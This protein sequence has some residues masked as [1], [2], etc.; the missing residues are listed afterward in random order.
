MA[1]NARTSL[2]LLRVDMTGSL[3]RPDRLK[4]TAARYGRGEASAEEFQRVQDECIREVIAT[5][6]AHG[7]PVLTDGEFRRANFQDSFGQAVT[8]FDAGPPDW[9]P[10]PLYDGATPFRRVESG[11]GGMGPAIVNRRPARE[12]LRLVRNVPL[13]EYQFSSQQTDRPVKVAL[14]G[15]DRIAQRFEWETSSAVYPDLDAF[16]AD[17]AALERQM[18]AELVAAGCRYVQLDEPGYTAYVD[19]PSLA[20]MRARGEDPEANMARSIAATNAILA[21]LGAVTTAVHICRG[22]QTG[23]WHREGS[24]DAIAERLFGELRCDR[25]L[26]EYDSERAGGFEPLRFVPKARVA[27]L[28]LITTKLP[29]LETVDEL[30]RRIEEASRYLPVEQLALS[31]QCGFG[32]F[33]ADVQWRKL[34]CM[35]ETAAQVWG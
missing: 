7:L 8:G 12:R 4:E 28:G 32:H 30:K 22:N 2:N 23:G 16:V 21:D 10:K 5:Q 17:T 1:V 27:V 13:E 14:V 35:L 24:Y 31:P 20:T 3:L 9:K 11:P 26:L 18:L 19:P 34:D 33:P 25:F 6:E 15:P 29:R